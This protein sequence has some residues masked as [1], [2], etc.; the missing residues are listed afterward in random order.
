MT[1]LTRSPRWPS[2]SP[3]CHC[4]AALAM[5]TTKTRSKK[6]SSGVA[7][8]C[9]SCGS[10]GS[11]RRDRGTT[12]TWLTRPSLPSGRSAVPSLSPARSVQAPPLEQ[13]AHV[14][15]GATELAV[16]LERI[17]GAADPHDVPAVAVSVL[18]R[19]AT[20]LAEP[21]HGD[22]VEHLAPDVGVVLRV[23]RVGERV[24]EVRRAVAGW[25]QRA[26]EPDLLER[27]RLEGLDVRHVRG[28]L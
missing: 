26:R 19:Q 4:A 28:L 6:S 23:V 2:A 10:R 13:V 18:P 24:R 22:G 9:A 27:C 11:M 7:T 14:G 1:K 21:R 3:W 17:G 15:V 20:V 8:R 25:D 5:A 12:L 16:G